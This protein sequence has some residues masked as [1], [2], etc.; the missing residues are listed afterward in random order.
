M[1]EQQRLDNG[2]NFEEPDNRQLWEQERQAELEGLYNPEDINDEPEIPVQVDFQDLLRN[3]I[4]FD[5][6]NHMDNNRNNPEGY[7][8]PEPP[9]DPELPELDP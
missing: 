6:D 8:Q 5:D 3:G 7:L 9:V 2:F 4:I 1:L